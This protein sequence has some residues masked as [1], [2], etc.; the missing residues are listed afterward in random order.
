MAHGAK[1]EG[2]DHVQHCLNHLA[3]QDLAQNFRVFDTTPRS[4]CFE[5]H[6]QLFNCSD[7]R[8]PDFS[9]LSAALVLVLLFSIVERWV[10]LL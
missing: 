8:N 2:L 10:C 1:G 5:K 9:D 3:T 4:E 6:L 7:S